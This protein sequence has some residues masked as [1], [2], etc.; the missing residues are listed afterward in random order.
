[1]VSALAA[2]RNKI[3]ELAAGTSIE[4]LSPFARF[5]FFC[6]TGFCAGVTSCSKNAFLSMK[7]VEIPE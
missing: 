5:R 7:E 6:G 1:M 2:V 4:E 3:I